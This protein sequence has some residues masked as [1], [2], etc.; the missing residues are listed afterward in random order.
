MCGD[1]S[2][3]QQGNHENAATMDG[4]RPTGGERGEG[5]GKLASLD[6]LSLDLET[7]DGFRLVERGR[8][9]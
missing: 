1:P 7:K 4:V 6:L 9:V 2:C 8:E 5:L 3:W